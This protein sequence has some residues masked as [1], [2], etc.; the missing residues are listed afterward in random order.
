M[1]FLVTHKLSGGGAEKAC[2]N[3]AKSLKEERLAA[4]II[5]LKPMASDEL[6]LCIKNLPRSDNRIFDIVR[7]FMWLVRFA[8]STSLGID[9]VLTFQTEVSIFTGVAFLLAGKNRIVVACERSDPFLYPASGFRRLLRRL[10]F[11]RLGGVICQSSYAATYFQNVKPSRRSVC[12]NI[13]SIE[14]EQSRKLGGG[15]GAIYFLSVGRLVYSKRVDLAVK[16]IAKLRLK[17]VAA[18]LDIIG[19]GP[20]KLRLAGVVEDH[21]LNEYVRFRGAM[22]NIEHWLSRAHYFLHLS[23]LEGMPNAVL[24]A[25]ASGLPVVA[26]YD[27]RPLRELIIEGEN[28]FLFKEFK[29]DEVVMKLAHASNNFDRYETLS[30]GARNSAKPFRVENATHSWISAMKKI[31]KLNC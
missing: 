16:V 9:T 22:D 6:D 14:V 19:D 28:G 20:D 13:V 18:F 12:Q 11:P 29:Q 3:L 25:L 31:G 30:I 1:I 26:N 10:L 5:C 17:G 15:D 21:D 27:C 2:L 23:E 4:Q 7:T 24:E 8:R